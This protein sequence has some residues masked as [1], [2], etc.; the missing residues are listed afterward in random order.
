MIDFLCS[1]SFAFFFI[2]RHHI[3]AFS[4]HKDRFKSHFSQGVNQVAATIPRIEG[5]RI[6]SDIYSS[7]FY[8]FCPFNQKLLVR[9]SMYLS[10]LIFPLHIFHRDKLVYHRHQERIQRC[11]CILLTRTT[12]SGLAGI[13]FFRL[14]A[15]CPF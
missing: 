15:D 2:N 4:V 9:T 13:V 6:V 7:P 3:V 5:D 8:I 14:F 12:K 10:S 1:E 11:E